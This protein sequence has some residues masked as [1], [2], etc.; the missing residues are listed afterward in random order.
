MSEIADRVAA[1]QRGENPHV[2]ARVPSGWAVM[3]DRQFPRG[4]CV[5]L[6]D[7]VVASLNDLDASLRPQFLADMAR[8]GDAV[9]AATNALRINYAIYGNQAPQLHAHVIPRYADEPA[10]MQAKARLALPAAPAR[11]APLRPRA[12]PPVDGEH[13]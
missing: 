6:A 13:P 1:A 10:D 8:L 3:S 2:I 5:L 7:P 12:R 4:W 11:R 9:L